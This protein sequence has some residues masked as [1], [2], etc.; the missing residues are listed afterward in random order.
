MKAQISLECIVI[1]AMALAIFSAAA[2]TALARQTDVRLIGS[3]LDSNN[4]CR[5]IA[6]DVYS[7]F[8]LGDGSQSIVSVYIPFNISGG[9][10]YVGS[11]IC[12]LCCNVTNGSSSDFWMPGGRIRFTNINGL[13]K[14][15][16]LW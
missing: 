13:I 8:L 5:K 6:N 16:G 2:M 15:E 10:A 9:S 11:A 14:L 12:K 7:L 1:F 3:A 4:E